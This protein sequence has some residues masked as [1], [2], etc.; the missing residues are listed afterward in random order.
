MAYRIPLASAGYSKVGEAWD[1][2][3]MARWRVGDPPLVTR[4]RDFEGKS[5]E[6]GEGGLRDYGVLR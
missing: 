6:W 1:I 4:F 5:G 3:A 2:G